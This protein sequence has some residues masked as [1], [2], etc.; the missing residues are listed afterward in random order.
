MA[1]SF[2]TP[3]RKKNT[4]EQEKHM[5]MQQK[6]SS[7]MNRPINTFSTSSKLITRPPHYSQHDTFLSCYEHSPL[8]KKSAIH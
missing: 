4:K 5:R 3:V 6:A 1:P 7:A 2:N 8:F